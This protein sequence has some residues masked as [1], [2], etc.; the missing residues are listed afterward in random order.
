[1]PPAS[2]AQDIADELADRERRKCN[3]IVYNFTE[4][5]DD[6]KKFIDMCNKVFKLEVQV[7]NH[8]PLG[9]QV[10]KKHRPL[11]VLLEDVDDKE[12]LT[13][14]SYLHRH[15]EEYK[16][17]IYISADMT[18]YQR[19]KHK[20]LVEKL[21]RRRAASKPNLTI[22]NGVIISKRP[23]REVKEATHHQLLIT[24]NSAQTL[25]TD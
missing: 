6:K 15:H 12:Y 21:K 5:S 17:N 9:R 22:R 7:I 4:S 11:L 2:F 18:K 19:S 1:L 25:T 16:K 8:G 23:Y 20:Q 13:Y 3:I 14:R 24:T 10:E